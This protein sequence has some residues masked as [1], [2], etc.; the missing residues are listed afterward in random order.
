MDCEGW[1]LHSD[2]DCK[3]EAEYSGDR[4]GLVSDIDLLAELNPDMFAAQT[5]QAVALELVAGYRSDM[6][7]V[8]TDIYHPAELAASNFVDD[9]ER[10]I[11]QQEA[12]DTY[13]LD[14]QQ[15]ADTWEQLGNSELASEL[16]MLFPPVDLSFG[17]S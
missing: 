16:D 14:L 7:D 2:P 13:E 9:S 11:A 5:E 12:E 1:L 8:D 15:H 3:S 6:M 17:L 10:T 4:F